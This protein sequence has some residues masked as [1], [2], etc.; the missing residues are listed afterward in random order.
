ML[1]EGIFDRRKDDTLTRDLFRS[2][3]SSFTPT[4][5]DSEAFIFQAIPPIVSLCFKRAQSPPLLFLVHC[6]SISDPNCSDASSF[7]VCSLLS[8]SWFPPPRA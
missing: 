4:P 8:A 7:L 6:V 5:C 1:A 3:R 2:F